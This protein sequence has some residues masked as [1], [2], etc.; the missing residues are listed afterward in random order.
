M[1][2]RL[3]SRDTAGL[4]IDGEP[5]SLSMGLRRCAFNEEGRKDVVFQNTR[6]ARCGVSGCGVSG[7]DA[8]RSARSR[9][10]RRVLIVRPFTSPDAERVKVTVYIPSMK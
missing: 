4:A 1:M 7:Y 10:T 3:I 5:G 2:L 6:A 8:S 9:R